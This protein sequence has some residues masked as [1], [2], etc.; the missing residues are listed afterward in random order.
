VQIGI[1][2]DLRNPPGWRREWSSHVERFLDRVVESE[3]LG[4][5]SVWLAEHHLFEDG[6]V[7]QPLV[8]AAAIAARTSRLRIGTAVLIAPLRQAIDIA[9]QSALVDLISGGRLELGLG[10]GYR[11]SEFAAFN[12][13]RDHR[14]ELLERRAREI[15]EVWQT[16]N[17]P[18]VQQRVPIWI[19]GRGP[20][21]A[22]IAGRLGEGLL[23]LDPGLLPHYREALAAHGHS[24]ARA[25]LGGIANLVLADD[26][27][28]A[29]AR[30]A[31]HL[32]YQR[33]SYRRGRGSDHRIDAGSEAPLRHPGEIPL[34]P[35]FDVV[36][37]DEAGLMLRSWLD[38]L[39]V[40]HV[41]FWD[42]IAGMPDDLIDR[43]IELLATRLRP[44]LTSDPA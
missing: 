44:I 29:W 21:S 40:E 3:R 6:Y 11:P 22:R 16:T 20:R 10:A 17:P 12:V 35:K 28:A 4:L 41:F 43:H 38:P 37:P 18:P 26:P 30:I 23:W 15:R 13:D 19:G 9:E 5:D 8:V 32:E 33:S 24:Q 42:S 1:Y 27:D 7:G 2:G 39:P 25:R 14:F 36:T 31:P 34:P